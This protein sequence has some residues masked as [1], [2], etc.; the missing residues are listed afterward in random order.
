MLPF[1]EPVPTGTGRAEASP[2]PC[3][4]LQAGV[5]AEELGEALIPRVTDSLLSS[6]AHSPFTDHVGARSALRGEHLRVPLCPRA[7]TDTRQSWT[8]RPRGWLPA[9]P[10]RASGRLGGF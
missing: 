5:K 8:G 4:A 1:N 10:A 9:W 6:G 7:G 2:E 3:T